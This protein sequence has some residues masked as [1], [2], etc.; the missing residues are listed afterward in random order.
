M[1][2]VLHDASF[3]HHVCYP[4][5]PRLDFVQE[6]ADG[7]KDM[8]YLLIHELSQL[9]YLSEEE[10]VTVLEAIAL[11]RNAQK[12]LEEKVDGC[13]P[14][15][16]II[17]DIENGKASEEYLLLTHLRMV[18]SIAMRFVSSRRVA[19]EDLVDE[20][21]FGLMLA[22]EKFQFPGVYFAFNKYAKVYIKS[23]MRKLISDT[24]GAIKLPP[25]IFDLRWKI[26]KFKSQYFQEH[27]KFPLPEEIAKN[28]F[29]EKLKPETVV[30]ILPTLLS[31]IISYDRLP[32]Y[33][34]NADQN[35]E[36]TIEKKLDQQKHDWLAE[37]VVEA[38]SGLNDFNQY[39]LQLRY[40]QN[41]TIS[42]TALILGYARSTIRL[43]EKDALE[44]FRE[45]FTALSG[46][47]SRD[48]LEAFIALV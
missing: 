41:Y 23:K 24:G 15:A 42:E 44:K 4:I 13:V 29:C 20:G 40:F 30:E 25:Y 34:S 6:V 46:L 3:H 48:E 8:V 19:Q 33:I 36:E 1:I 47:Q 16:G 22:I 31:R 32:I 35:V 26:I 38:L 37:V 11:G 9:P 10:K 17:F 39:I 5:Q 12:Q 27:G 14:D 2:E 28:V 18:P 7:K 43:K 21:V 45:R